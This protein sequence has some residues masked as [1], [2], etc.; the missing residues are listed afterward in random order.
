VNVGNEILNVEELRTV[1]RLVKRNY[2]LAP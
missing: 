2:W 1:G